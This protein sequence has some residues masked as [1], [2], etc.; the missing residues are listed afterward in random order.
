MLKV[1]EID[2]T[3]KDL[4]WYAPGFGI[5]GSEN[6]NEF[7]VAEC[8]W[9]LIDKTVKLVYFKNHWEFPHQDNFSKFLTII[10]LIKSYPTEMYFFYNELKS[11]EVQVARSNF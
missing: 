2:D 5:Y 4:K 7:V 1:L 8:G 9:C 10:V 6:G 11:S 3:L